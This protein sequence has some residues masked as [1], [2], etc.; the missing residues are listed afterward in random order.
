VS[1]DNWVDMDA[2]H[3]DPHVIHTLGFLIK[4]DK[5]CIVVAM[6][7]D[8]ERDARSMTMTI[9]RAWI[10]EVRYLRVKVK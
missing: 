4:E 6:Q 5:S 7:I 3:E 2:E 9:P 10:L 8:T 1:D